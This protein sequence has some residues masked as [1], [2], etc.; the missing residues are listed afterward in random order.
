MIFVL[1][2]PEQLVENDHRAGT[3]PATELAK[4]GLGRTVQ[5]RIDVQKGDVLALRPRVQ[6]FGQALIE[7][8]FV[9]LDDS[10]FRKGKVAA[11]RKLAPAPGGTRG[12]SHL[13]HPSHQ[14]ATFL[15]D[16]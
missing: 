10:I 15:G 5:I 7:P 1:R 16:R 14:G 12:A 2:I 6:E 4:D 3:Q 13:S 9:P 8:A 11:Q